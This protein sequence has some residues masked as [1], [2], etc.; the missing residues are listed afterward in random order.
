MQCPYCKSMDDRVINSRTSTD[1]KSVKRRRECI[2]CGH[3]FTTYERI[4]E[5]ILRVVKKDGSRDD[6][7]RAKILAGLMK[8]CYKRPIGVE[9]LENVVDEI[10]TDLYRKYD[11]E[12]PSN[13]IGE[14]IM[15]RLRHLDHVAYIRFASVYREFKD[16]TDFVQ[17]ADTVLKEDSEEK[18]R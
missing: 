4:E 17:E 10:E 12:V 16:V 18:A 5:T 8:A 2:N 1:G 11:R 13:V 14:M 6:F 9:Q 7:E 15:E 3:R